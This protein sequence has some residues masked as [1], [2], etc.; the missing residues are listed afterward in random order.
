HIKKL[1]YCDIHLT[2]HI[3]NNIVYP[4]YDNLNQ[5]NNLKFSQFFDI[6]KDDDCIS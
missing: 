5:N 6:N 4:K 2:K 3:I 1:V